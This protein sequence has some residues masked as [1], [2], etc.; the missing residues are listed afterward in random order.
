MKISFIIKNINVKQ[1]FMI[2][3]YTVKLIQKNEIAENTIQLILTKPEGFSFS[4]GQFMF[5]DF[6]NPEN[7]DDKPTFRAMSIASAPYE[8]NL[9][10]VM[11][12]SESAFKKNVKSMNEGDE[13]VIKGPMGHVMLP[14][15]MIQ[16]IALLVAG[17]GITPARSIIKHEEHQ[18]ANRQV[19]LL[20]S[21]K[22]KDSIALYEDLKDIQLEN[23][24]PVFTLTEESNE[25]NGEVG[26]I[27]EEM[28][29]KHIDEIEKTMYYIVGTKV[30]TDAMKEILDN[31]GISKENIQFDNFG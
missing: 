2:S 31:M 25:W 19:T 3:Q 9:M 30:F 21:N 14:T 24:K 27:N 16:P 26:R 15:N 23:Y 10:F 22:T 1:Y 20:Y 17:V 4:P 11:R 6:L 8:E 29:R 12:G 18:K 13:L 5:L 7:T 28:I